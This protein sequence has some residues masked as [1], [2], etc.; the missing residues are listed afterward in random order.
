MTQACLLV[1]ILSAAGPLRTQSAIDPAT[2]P[3]PEPSVLL[4]GL[5]ERQRQHE[6]ALNDYTYDV[7]EREETLDGKGAVKKVKERG[8]EVFQV[9]RRPVRRQVSED[10]R[11]LSAERQA[12][13]DERVEDTVQ[14]LLSEKQAKK[15]DEILLSDVLDHYEFKTIA[16][17]EIGGRSVIVLDFSPGSGTWKVE[18]ANVLRALAG[19]LWIDEQERQ[20]VKATLRNLSKIKFLLGIGASV[21][22]LDVTMEFQRLEEG[23][24]LPRVVEGRVV[25]RFLLFKGFRQRGSETYSRYRRFQTATE[26]KVESPE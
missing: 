3:L 26:E 14:K 12:K 20:V 16:R 7:L 11:P 4:A 19:R 8:F 25:G 18:H 10:G 21:S 5:A 17:E 15:K 2:T 1:L 6:D 9:K 13:E 23:L 22:E 24:W